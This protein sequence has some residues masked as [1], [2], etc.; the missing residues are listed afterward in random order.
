MRCA[1]PPPIDVTSEL[2]LDMVPKLRFIAA[3]AMTD[4]EM[5]HEASK[6]RVLNEL[7]KRLRE[8]Q[9]EDGRVPPERK[10][11]SVLSASRRAVRDALARLEGEGIVWRRQ[12]QG[13]FTEAQP[14]G[15]YRDIAKLAHRV[16]PLEIVE[17][18]L[19][20]EPMLAHRSALRASL[21][22]IETMKR[23]AERAL[24][25]KNPVDYTR[26]DAAFHRKIAETAGNALFPAM[27]EMI[28]LVR[29][30]VDW[31]RVRRYYFRHDGARR[32]YDEHSVILSAIFSRDP[33]AAEAAM[34]DHLESVSAVFLEM[35]A[36]SH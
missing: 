35:T 12:G 17:T 16:N 20:I 25:A 15:G 10:L 14:T 7:R 18:R 24:N 33:P 3:T 2:I 34:R 6:E 5:A 21:A 30:K 29:E 26:A 11:A 1:I 9:Y 13:T 4:Q 31:E 32:S 23:I 8:K 22:D 28:I 36:S 27:F 19:A